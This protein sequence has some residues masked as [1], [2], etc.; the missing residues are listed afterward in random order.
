MHTLDPV[1]PGL[2]A[3]LSGYFSF[4]PYT[5]NMPKMADHTDVRWNPELQEW[6]CAKCGQTSDH[7]E[8]EDAVREMETFDCSIHGTTVARLGEKERL[9]RVHYL[10]KQRKSGK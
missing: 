8:R 6:F 9:L 10:N 7:K 1:A 4:D 5:A 3:S 2:P